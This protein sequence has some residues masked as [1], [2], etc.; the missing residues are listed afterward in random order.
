M[1]ILGRQGLSLA[2]APPRD[3]GHRAP[4]HCHQL[5]SQPLTFPIKMSIMVPLFLDNIPVPVPP[6]TSINCLI[7]YNYCVRLGINS[8]TLVIYFRC[9]CNVWKCIFF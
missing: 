5:L 8:N 3:P 4:E 2:L 6:H 1:M 7:S 9:N